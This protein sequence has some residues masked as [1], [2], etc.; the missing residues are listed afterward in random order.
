MSFGV[1]GD[2]T[3]GVE[4]AKDAA[5]DRSR[6]AR[7]DA[8]GRQRGV[9]EAPDLLRFLA[10]KN[11]DQMFGAKALAGT[12]KGRQGHARLGRRIGRHNAV[13]ADVAVAA[14]F[15]LFAEIGAQHAPTASR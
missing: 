12:Q 4:L 6:A 9:A 14:G 11:V 5:P 1:G 3:G 7:A 15:G 8:K 13:E 2:Q 10:Q